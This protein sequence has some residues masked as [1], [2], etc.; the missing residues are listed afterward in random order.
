[1]EVIDVIS[2]IVLGAVALAGMIIQKHVK[3]KLEDMDGMGVVATAK[4]ARGILKI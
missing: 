1:L 3:R 4:E 2:V